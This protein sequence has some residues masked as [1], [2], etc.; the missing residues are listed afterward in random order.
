MEETLSQ[1]HERVS[2]QDSQLVESRLE[3]LAVRE[4]MDEYTQLSAELG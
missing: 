3:T 4:K 2:E 1:L